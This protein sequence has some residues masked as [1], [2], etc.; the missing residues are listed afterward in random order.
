MKT[1]RIVLF[2]AGIMIGFICSSSKA[3]IGTRFPSERKVVTDPVTGVKL[4]FLISTP[5]GDS[6]IY[7]DAFGRWKIYEY[8]YY[9]GSRRVAEPKV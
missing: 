8:L 3:Q 1:K 7:P 9:P 4:I 5:A 6:K 2:M